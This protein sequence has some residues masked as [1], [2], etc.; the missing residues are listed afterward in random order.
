[1][2]LVN[3]NNL[4]ISFLGKELFHELDFQSEPGERIGLVGPNGSGKTTLL[5]LLTGE[6][7][8]EKGEIKIAGGTRT[9]YLPG[10]P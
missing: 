8:P 3:I 9:G 1:M 10:C 2:S 6:V 5:R 7:S 4:S